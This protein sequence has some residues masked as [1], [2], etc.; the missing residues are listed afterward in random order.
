MLSNVSFVTGDFVT[1]S[2]FLTMV[3][4]FI[5]YMSGFMKNGVK[6]LAP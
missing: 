5:L 2:Y 6:E 1:F 4:H 3:N